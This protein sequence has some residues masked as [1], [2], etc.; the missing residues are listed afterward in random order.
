MLGGLITGCGVAIMHY[1]GMAAMEVHTEANP[2]MPAGAGAMDLLV[3]LIL[4]VSMVTAVLLLTIGVSPSE[5]E[6]RYDERL[7]QRRAL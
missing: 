4:G 1:T 6:R 2:G 7:A 5:A 3:P